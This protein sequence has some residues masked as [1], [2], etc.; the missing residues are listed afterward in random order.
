VSGKTV[1]EKND[2]F[3]DRTRTDRVFHV[4]SVGIIFAGKIYFTP[5]R[6]ICTMKIKIFFHGGF[7]EKTSVRIQLYIALYHLLYITLPNRGMSLYH[8][9][10]GR[11]II[12][13]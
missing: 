2:M 11:D 7:S 10:A 12:F 8:E 6:E 13:L 1:A 9:T 4:Y 5:D 3:K